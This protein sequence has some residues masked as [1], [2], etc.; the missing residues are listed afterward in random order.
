MFER[1]KLWVGFGVSYIQHTSATFTIITWIPGLLI[2]QTL[3]PIT[4]LLFVI[5]AVSFISRWSP[6]IWIMFSGIGGQNF[7]LF[8]PQP[9][10]LKT[11]FHVVFPHFLTP[12]LQIFFLFCPSFYVAFSFRVRMRNRRVVTGGL[13]TGQ[14]LFNRITS[15]VC[16][17]FQNFLPIF[18]SARKIIFYLPDVPIT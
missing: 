6:F 16:M 10:F 7:G 18:S 4:W 14:R 9:R 2:M 15:P 13:K 1:L 5:A 8:Y 3:L 12:L 11:I 17:I